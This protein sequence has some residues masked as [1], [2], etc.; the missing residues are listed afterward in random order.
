MGMISASKGTGILIFIAI[1]LSLAAPAMAATTVSSAVASNTT[2]TTGTTYYIASADG[3]LSVINNATLVIQR[4]VVIKFGDNN[5]FK[6]E[7]GGK[8]IAQGID[9]NKI[10]FTSCKD[11]TFGDD[12][13]G[14]GGCSGSAAAGDY[15]Y[16]IYLDPTAGDHTDVN[17]SDLNISFAEKGMYIDSDMN[18]IY[19]CNIQN[20]GTT[21]T[22]SPYY[23][24]AGIRIDAN[25]TYFHNNT[26]KNNKLDIASGTG[27]AMYIA[28]DGNILYFYNNYFSDNNAN[29]GG[30]IYN[31]YGIITNFYNNTFYKNTGHNSGGFMHA[32]AEATITNFY[33]NNFSYNYSTNPGAGLYVNAA[34]ITNFY[35]NSFTYNL[36][37]NYGGGFYNDSSATIAS[38]HDNNFSNN[39]GDT[40]GFHTTGGEI[41][42]FYNNIF[43]DNNASVNGAGFFNSADINAVYNNL[44]SDNNLYAG[45][46]GGG[47]H[48]QGDINHVYDNNFLRNYANT[49][50]GGFFHD[51]GTITNF[52]NNL[53][54][55]NNATMGGGLGTNGGTITNIYDNNFTGNRG[56]TNGYSGAIFN[57]SAITNLYNNIF[58]KNIGKDSGGIYNGL[59]ITNLYDNNFLNNTTYSNGNGG[60]IWNRNTITNLYNNIFSDNNAGQNGGAIFQYNTSGSPEITNLY[61]NTFSDNNA[62]LGG[63]A[64]CNREAIVA[65]HDNNF[66]NN[67]VKGINY[68]GAIYNLAG[69]ITG[70]YDNNFF[71]N[72]AGYGGA[73]Y[74][75][76]AITDLN[77]NAFLDNNAQRKAGAVYSSAAITNIY[78]NDFR[79]NI[80]SMS[81]SDYEG[82]GAIY[83]ASGG[84]ITS[85]HDNN[86]SDNS[87]TTIQDYCGGGAIYTYAN[88][89]GLYDNN[90]SN[91]TSTGS[92]TFS[93]GGAIYNYK[94]ITNLYDNNFSDNNAATS[95]T[96]SGGGAI[97]NY[98]DMLNLYDNNFFSNVSEGTGLYSGGGA[99]YNDKNISHVY[100]N[101]FVSN[102]ADLNG[103][104]IFNKAVSSRNTSIISLHNNIFSNNSAATGGAIS[105]SGNSTTR[106]ANINYVY[107]NTFSNNTADLGGAIFNDTFRAN[108]FD[109]NS[110][111]FSDNNATDGG[112]V[113]NDNDI[114][115]IYDNNFT[116][117]TADDFGAGIYN[118]YNILSLYDNNFTSNNTSGSGGAIHNN[119]G[120]IINLHDN[121]FTSN[122]ADINGGAI[123][124]R[125]RITNLYDNNFS[126]NNATC[127]GAI[128]N[129]SSNAEI[130]DL[131]SN[132]FSDNNATD[133]GTIYNADSALIP[134]L[135]SNIF[136]N[137]TAD[138]F[139]AGIYNNA[140]T[141]TNLYDNNFF[142]N[143]ATSSGGAVSN[144]RGTITNLHDNNFTSNTADING[145]AIHNDNTITS[146][147]N[148][149]FTR[150]ES[151]GNGNGAGIHNYQ[152][153]II[154]SLY[155]NL[156]VGDLNEALYNSAGGD[157]NAVFN[158]TFTFHTKGIHDTNTTSGTQYYNNIFVENTTGIQYESGSNVDEN[159][160]AFW[161][162][163]TNCTGASCGQY[164]AYFTEFPFLA[165]N[166]DLNHAVKT[167]QAAIATD[168]GTSIG[169]DAYFS[170]KTIRADNVLD[171]G[172]RDIGYHY[173]TNAIYVLVVSPNGGETWRA[174]ETIDFNVNTIRDA[175][176]CKLEIRYSVTADRGSGTVIIED[177]NMAQTIYC[178]SNDFTQI[179]ACHYDWDTSAV[180]DGT[181]YILI[182]VNSGT[183][184]NAGFLQGFDASDASFITQQNTAPDV[185]VIKI[186]TYPDNQ[187][188]PSFSY[189]ADANLTIDFNVFD[190]DNDRLTVDINYSS[191]NTEGAGTKIVDDMNLVSAVCSDQDWNDDPSTCS[192]D[193]NIHSSLISSDGNYF[194]LIEVSDAIETDFNASDNN[195][196]V[197]NTAPSTT[198]DANSSTWQNFDANVTLTC[199][200]ANSGCSVTKYKMDS[201]SSSTVNFGSWQTWD[202]NGLYFYKDGN[203]AI[204]FNSTDVAGN[205]ETTNRAHALIDKSAPSTTADYNANWQTMDA[206]VLLTCTDDSGCQT[207]AYRLDTDSGSG[208]TIGSWQTYDTNI[209]IT[210][211]GNWAIDFNSTDNEGIIEDANR[212]Y[213][214][215]DKTIPTISITSPSNR[216]N[217]LSPTIRVSYTGSDGIGSGIKK[218][219]FSADSNNAWIDNNLS[220]SY[221][222]TNQ[223]LGWH[224]YYIKA[225]D[226][227]D[228]NSSAATVSVYR[229]VVSGGPEEPGGAVCGNETCESGEN[230]SNCPRDCGCAE[231]YECVDGVCQLS[232][233]CGDG[234]IQEGEECE[235]DSDCPGE[236]ID[237]SW[238]ECVSL[239]GKNCDVLCEERGLIASNS[240]V[241]SRGEGIACMELWGY[242]GCEEGRSSTST[243][244]CLDIT[245]SHNALWKCCCGLPSQ[246]CEDCT[247]T[248]TSLTCSQRGGYCCPGAEQCTGDSLAVTDCTEG[249]CCSTPCIKE[250]DLTVTAFNVPTTVEWN[251]ITPKRTEI[252]ATVRNNGSFDANS[253]SIVLLAKFRREP[254]IEI[255]E[256]RIE[257]IAGGSQ[258]SLDFS[259]TYDPSVP[260]LN[261]WAYQNVTFT[262]V[263]DYHNEI[264]ESDET[265]NQATSTTYFG[266]PEVCYNRFDDDADGLVDERPCRQLE[267]VCGDGT[268]QEGEECEADSDCT[269][270]AIDYSW[271]EC[272]S[273]AGKN[274]DILCEARGLIASNFCVPTRGEGLACMELWGYGG[275][276]EGRSSTSTH[277]CLD[278]TVRHD[279]L[280]KCCCG[281]P[282]RICD[283]CS[284][285]TGLLTCSQREGYCCTGTGQCTGK[286][287]TVKD[288]Y[289]G[290]CCSTPCVTPPELSITA[291]NVPTTVEWNDITPKMAEISVTIRNNGT[292]DAHSFGVALMA[293]AQGETSS[294]E[295]KSR[296]IETIAG[297]RQLSINLSFTY[298]PSVPDLNAWAYQ[299]VIFTVLVDYYNVVIESDETNNQATATSYFG[300]PEIPDNG[301][302]DDG[303]G[304]A[305]EGNLPNLW[306]KAV[307]SGE[308]LYNEQGLTGIDF[309][310]AVRNDYVDI[311]KSFEIAFYKSKLAGPDATIVK[312]PSMRKDKDIILQFTWKREGGRIIFKDKEKEKILLQ[313]IAATTP[314]WI[315]VDSKGFT[316]HTA[317]FIGDIEEA[318]EKDNLER[319]NVKVDLPDLLFDS[320]AA[321][322]TVFAGAPIIINASVLN[323]GEGVA[324]ASDI[325]VYID[326]IAVASATISPL[327]PDTTERILFSID[328]S[329]IAGGDHDIDIVIDPL[330][331]VIESEEE[332][333]SYYIKLTILE[334]TGDL[335]SYEHFLQTEPIL[336]G[337]WRP[338]TETADYGFEIQETQPSLLRTITDTEANPEYD[339]R[340][341]KLESD[342]EQLR[343]YNL[344]VSRQTR[345]FGSHEFDLVNR[346][347]IE[348]FNQADNT[349]VAWWLNP[350]YLKRMHYERINNLSLMFWQMHL[351][352]GGR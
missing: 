115:N 134:D 288:C 28:S 290:I 170:V 178:D 189:Y 308:P 216:S 347:P 139:G 91:N 56:A 12:L 79:S 93:G 36:T 233:V 110:N 176:N 204:D 191:G 317:G 90:F 171:S 315:L 279:A 252:S 29:G 305:D 67:I 136:S 253:F 329:S 13:S 33:D 20:N 342:L 10:H 332:N 203:W 108:I 218:Y 193:F 226:N 101:N 78:S 323:D 49:Y 51:T 324:N 40:G 119:L 349:S 304:L 286:R 22:L 277:P 225:T 231:G 250:I 58:S 126:N 263:A 351:E 153:G 343:Q 146:L 208:V 160:N 64:I 322:N 260:D 234:I 43:T 198:S 310:I 159:Y 202:G 321:P 81:A 272:V 23:Q 194:I 246:I 168:Q 3:N 73:V 187:G 340:I 145:G 116:S 42:N 197:D 154:V 229:T 228:L 254:T 151:G 124:N 334:L 266:G 336:F 149:T 331:D 60:A 61:N 106:D 295:I 177:Q 77:H 223:G 102:T 87:T 127:G 138:N 259:F 335:Y 17:W 183:D 314:F 209:L 221:T 74:S 16:A 243:H 237:Y 82:G 224:T 285:K 214:L 143:N 163:D 181:Y 137:N 107:S 53:L 37:T 18:S 327:S 130:S 239:A 35:N 117:N 249:V 220:T 147:Y 337:L 95:D 27:G 173:D 273:L 346:Q 326:G 68:G 215:I 235:A 184:V 251:D 244:P 241:P 313:G 121:N 4:G 109:L 158:N 345:L 140:G 294:E 212:I 162:N 185:N 219:W 14:E 352:E 52:Y 114:D 316:G 338:K 242:G 118:D 128:Y 15:N 44:F 104:A 268:I 248:A 262:V 330:D 300:G 318:S 302:D 206:N 94:V 328:S 165:D 320:V 155:N 112:A 167:S 19:D 210:A 341:N 264:T 25:V 217:T 200:D 238:T 100:D 291:F 133:G 283:D 207:T 132:T 298:D 319:M 103:G 175:A 169:T 281:L 11:Q 113:Y 284:C 299:N 258:L 157:L 180:P 7:D 306:I 88:I 131:N 265:N 54:V 172:T 129:Y 99:I 344:M 240:C 182:D 57:Y 255:E 289:T 62:G 297:G 97:Y 148:N 6:I 307:Q 205:I 301:E 195:F 21:K 257:T 84:T 267:D 201:D 161:G 80:V 98:T 190:S 312:I 111:A 55:D 270:E 271:T 38:F 280:W 69:T 85:L 5:Y 65:L 348:A 59:T 333:N 83:C 92:R 66:S 293:R 150:N 89:T 141:I 71:N 311:N 222:F 9:S 166:S 34:T 24:G 339:F 325:A 63:G 230:C 152:D 296:R 188:L 105:I 275:C 122:T 256:R 1:L 46:H 72:E 274:C 31:D 282:S 48:N 174:T 144:Y 75:T 135:N 30:A 261:A 196:M 303:D 125:E 276:E 70:L 32:Q 309:N 86:F 41:T 39:G 278:I 96:Y 211:D 236:A 247:C 186:D 192:W 213:V 8:L 142:N 156:F 76:G 2:W 287:L 292:S 50:G 123:H 26:F 350:I 45:N 199:T 227:V 47:M 232:A 120:T 245:V 269:T 179:R 164:D